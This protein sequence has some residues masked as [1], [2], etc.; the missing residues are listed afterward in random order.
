MWNPRFLAKNSK[1]VYNIR[2]QLHIKMYRMSWTFFFKDKIVELFFVLC[3]NFHKTE[4][5]NNKK[6]LQLYEANYAGL[7]AITHIL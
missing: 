3:P 1:L 6:K 5:K 4:K 7:D 2:P